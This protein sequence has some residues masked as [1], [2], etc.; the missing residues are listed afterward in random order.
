[1]NHGNRFSKERMISIAKENDC[2]IVLYGH[3]HVKAIEEVKGIYLCNPGSVSRPRK[4]NNKTFLMIN[5]DKNSLKLDFEFVKIN[6]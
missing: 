4:G 1:M 3:T 5:Y 2:K 6:L